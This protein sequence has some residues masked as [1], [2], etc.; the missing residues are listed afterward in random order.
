MAR[1]R[2]IAGSA[3]GR[4]LNVAGR[5]V[6]PTPAVIREAL[7]SILAPEA[8]GDFL[9]LFAGCGSVGLEAAS[10]GWQVTLVERDPVAARVLRANALRLGLSVDLHTLDAE[11][12][13]EQGRL[14]DA[15]FADPPY[16]F[17]AERAQAIALRAAAPGG[18]VVLQHP[19]QVH[20]AEGERRVYGTNAITL[21]R[22]ME[23]PEE[24]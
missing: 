8:R 24:S 22:R 20:L 4:Q 6:R 18:I 7:F 23:A 13:V 11:R 1:P 5:E 10:R 12:F 16:R 19:A 2:I 9:D 15:V 14:F 3:K 21:L 17:E